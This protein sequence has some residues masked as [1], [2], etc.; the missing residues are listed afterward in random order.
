MPLLPLYQAIPFSLV[1]ENTK[2]M[3]INE[4]NN[5]K[6]RVFTKEIGQKHPLFEIV[7]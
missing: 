4:K 3:K 6:F 1:F 2:R 7:R 5:A